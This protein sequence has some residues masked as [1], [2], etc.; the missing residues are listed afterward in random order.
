MGNP[1]QVIKIIEDDY[2]IRI[3]IYDGDG[4]T[5]KQRRLMDAI[6][7]QFPKEAR[8]EFV[9]KSAIVHELEDK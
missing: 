9:E 5:D 8:V 1:E 2:G 6:V 7:K 3:L 4:Y